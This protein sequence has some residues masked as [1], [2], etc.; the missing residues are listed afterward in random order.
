MGPTSFFQ[1]QVNQ[2]WTVVQCTYPKFGHEFIAAGVL[3]LLLAGATMRL[4]KELNFKKK[5]K[6]INQYHCV[7]IFRFLYKK[8]LIKLDNI[9]IELELSQQNLQLHRVLDV[10]A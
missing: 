1:P 7:Y 2:K 5:I 10:P 9:L 6:I 4:K 3:L 8:F